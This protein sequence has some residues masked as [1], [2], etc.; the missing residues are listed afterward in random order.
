MDPFTLLFLAV[1]VW[2]TGEAVREVRVRAAA[3]ADRIEVRRR[4]PRPAMP[5]PAGAAA[6]RLVRNDR[7]A[8]DR[9]PRHLHAPHRA[10]RT[11]SRAA[12]AV[13]TYPALAW[14]MP[15]AFFR[16][17]RHGRMVGRAWR[18]NGGDLDAA[19][20]TAA[21]TATRNG[22]HIP[23]WARPDGPRRHNSGNP[24]A[25]APYDRT[26][27]PGAPGP[28]IPDPDTPLTAV[29]PVPTATATGIDDAEL[30]PSPG[31]IAFLRAATDNT[32]TPEGPR[33]MSDITTAPI[34]AIETGDYEAL[35]FLATHA[36]RLGQQLE[37]AAVDIGRLLATYQNAAENAAAD[38]AAMHVD[39]ATQGEITEL[40]VR[41]SE[42]GT[43]H[44]R[45]GQLAEALTEAA[46]VLRLGLTAR[47]GGIH[48]AVTE[49]P[50]ARAADGAFY[51]GQAA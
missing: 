36:G 38:A 3:R 49:S 4:P 31:D 10:A 6:P 28:R 40:H 5:G 11:G 15:R 35:Q 42:I 25:A 13:T 22:W 7:H 19:T 51:G 41:L 30:V 47:H 48:D 33:T 23:D 43:A 50:L 9:G 44:A 18:R 32:T 14:L 46:D 21:D 17:W 39:S 27:R 12:A 45:L 24:P 37:E 34:G 26:P 2:G 16:G 1:F 29:E 8:P 20:R